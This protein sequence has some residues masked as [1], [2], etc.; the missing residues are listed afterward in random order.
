[1]SKVLERV[2]QIQNEVRKKPSSLGRMQFLSQLE[3]AYGF[4]G[5][6]KLD[7]TRRQ[8]KSTLMSTISQQNVMLNT[9]GRQQYLLNSLFN[10]KK[11][12]LFE[13]DLS[14]FR[15]ETKKQVDDLRNFKTMPRTQNLSPSKKAFGKKKSSVGGGASMAGRSSKL[16]D[17]S[18]EVS[19]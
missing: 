19:N 4:H 2:K 16:T 9:E 8:T 1:M 14:A 12:P 17:H 7:P 5:Y 10:K 3:D 11:A 15:E 6:K 18:Q 13:T